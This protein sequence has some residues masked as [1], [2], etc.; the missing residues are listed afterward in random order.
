MSNCQEILEKFSDNGILSLSFL[1]FGIFLEI[2]RAETCLGIASTLS[3]NSESELMK[4]T[5]RMLSVHSETI[6]EPYI[7]VRQLVDE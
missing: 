3:I 2:F 1:P 6:W 4:A 7:E 5:R